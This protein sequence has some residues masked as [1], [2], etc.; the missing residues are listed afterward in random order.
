[1]LEKKRVWGIVF[2]YTGA[3]VGAGFASGRE[4]WQFFARHQLRGLMGIFF[5]ALFF[6]ILVPF[7]L[8]FTRK[9]KIDSYH[10]V[11]Y[12]Y[13][14]KYVA[15]G[16]DI[17]YALFLLGSIAVMLAGSATVF[18]DVLNL[19]Y[20]LGILLTLFLVLII[21]YLKIEGI[22]IVNSYLVPFL[23]IIT[24]ITVIKYFIDINFNF[25]LEFSVNREGWITDS[26]L[27][28]S[29]NLIMAIAIMTSIVN[30][31]E[32]ETIFWGTFWGGIV[33]FLLNIVIFTGLIIA[34]TS[35]PL[36]EIPMLYL[37]Q[38]GGKSIFILYIVSLY[39]AM[40]S[41]II[42]NYFAFN[43][44]LTSLLNLKYEYSLLLT[45]IFVLPLVYL[46]FSTLVAK[47][48]T[49][50][51]YLAFIILSFY[52]FVSLKDRFII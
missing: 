48:Y 9:L 37:A 2:T 38:K 33:L 51:G 35:V 41:T 25:V 1:M 6:T 16:F 36:E 30:K 15:F 21:L 24:I 4:I 27:Y 49:A 50:Y 47:L 13:L 14:P 5:T 43:Y 20:F 42:A 22:L 45:L 7:F 46:G 10:L 29:Y 8:Q 39:F 26:I 32:K 3:V 44:R 17:I 11:F 34:F 23:V 12:R 52:L 28:A 19:P 31:E 18:R 40:V